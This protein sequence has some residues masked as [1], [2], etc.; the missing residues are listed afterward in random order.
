MNISAYL[1][2]LCCL[3]KQQMPFDLSYKPGTRK[4]E[5][6]LQLTVYINPKT[7][8]NFEL[9]NTETKD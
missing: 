5:P 3:L 9:M 4:D 1:A 2:M 8:L 7:S 6:S